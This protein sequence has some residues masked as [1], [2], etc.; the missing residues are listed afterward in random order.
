M[1]KEALPRITAVSPGARLMTLSVRWD[2]GDRTVVDVS[3][4][5]E[6]FAVY[7]PLRRSPEMFRQARVGE[8]GTDVVWTNGIEMSADTIWRLAQ[9]QMVSERK[10]LKA[11]FE[12]L[13]DQPKKPFP[14]A[15][16]RLDVPCARGVYVIYS[17]NG[18]PLHVGSTPRGKG[19]LRQRLND[20]LAGRSSF[21]VKHLKR[22]FQQLRNGYE[23]QYVEVDDYRRRALLE[24]LAAGQLCPAHIGRGEDDAESGREEE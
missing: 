12:S 1:S 6:H 7:A 10:E 17:P 24:A 22:D 11:L 5:I 3:R 21:T 15:R 9:D 19:G 13:I 4:L 2:S 14:K 18:R 16:E 8:Y 23:F 20:H